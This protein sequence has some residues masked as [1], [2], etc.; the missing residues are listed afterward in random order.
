MEVN[1]YHLFGYQ[2]SSKHVLLGSARANYARIFIFG[3][4]RQ[5]NSFLFYYFFQSDIYLSLTTL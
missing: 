2:H 1:S 5:N 4:I 3:Y